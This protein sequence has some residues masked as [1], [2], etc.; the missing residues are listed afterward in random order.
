M[1]SLHLFSTLE[2]KQYP[3]SNKNKFNASV[4]IKKDGEPA[5]LCKNSR[6]ISTSDVLT[7]LFV[8]FMLGSTTQCYLQDIS[9]C[10][11]LYKTNYDAIET[12]LATIVELNFGVGAVGPLFRTFPVWRSFLANGHQQ[13][14]F[15][16][17][18]QGQ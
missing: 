2:I 15:I 9:R 18:I 6:S 8:T 10:F 5:D 17:A 3:V 12:C 1:G 7:L 13:S 14:N 4:Q 16:S 11:A